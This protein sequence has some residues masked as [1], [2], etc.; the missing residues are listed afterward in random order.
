MIWRWLRQ[1][2]VIAMHDEQIAEHGGSPGLRDAGL[3]SSA[4]TRPQNK[5][6]YETPSVFDLAAAYAA[7]IIQNHPFV[8]GNKRTGFLAAYVFLGLNG[9]DLVASEA[10]AVG[11]VLALAL[12]EINEDHFSDWLKEHAIREPSI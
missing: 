9:W 1:D 5:E 8:D 6:V 10:D 7:G 11:A 4:L 2:V 12:R 3:L